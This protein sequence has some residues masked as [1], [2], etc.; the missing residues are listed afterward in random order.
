MSNLSKEIKEVVKD[1]REVTFD[2]MEPLV[3]KVLG[4]KNEK[5]KK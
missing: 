1:M 3:D 4:E 2:A 5:H